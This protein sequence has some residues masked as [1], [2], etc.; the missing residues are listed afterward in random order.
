MIINYMYSAMYKND[1]LH[2]SFMKCI[3][4]IELSI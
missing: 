3:E 2:F 1:N 4:Y